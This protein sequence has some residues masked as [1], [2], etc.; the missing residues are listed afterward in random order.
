MRAMNVRYNG[1][2]RFLLDYDKLIYLPIVLFTLVTSFIS[3]WKHESFLTYAWD[4][5]AYEQSLWTTLKYGKLLWN[6]PNFGHLHIHL[7]LILFLIFPLYAIY[8][9]P[10]T[11]LVIQSFFVGMSALPVYLIAK[12]EFEDKKL[13]FLFASLYLLYTP[14]VSILNFDFHSDAFIP[15][16]LSFSIYYL[17]KEKW[18]KYLLFLF[19]TLMCKE[20]VPLVTVFLGIYIILTSEVK[21]NSLSNKCY[22]AGMLKKN[23]K[24]FFGFFTIIISLDWFLLAQIVMQY[25][26]SQTPQ[27]AYGVPYVHLLWWKRFGVSIPEI[28]ANI[29]LKPMLT[30]EALTYRLNEKIFYVI[31]LLAPFCFISFKKPW[32][33]LVPAPYLMSL[34]L[35]ENYWYWQLGLFY[36]SLIV[37]FVTVSSIYGIKSLATTHSGID[38]A[39]VKK[40]MSIVA[41]SILIFTL[42]G[43]S[44]SIPYIPANS[45]HNEALKRVIELIPQNASVITQNNI[46]PHLSHRLNVYPGYRH[47]LEADYILVDMT[48]PSFGEKLSTSF[49]EPPGKVLFDLVTK[50]NYTVVTAIDGII[51]LKRDYKGPF[52]IPFEQALLVKFFNNENFSGEPSFITLMLNVDWKHLQHWQD[53]SPFV[54]VKENNI[55]HFIH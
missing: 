27:V 30:L 19:L 3:I 50:Y 11:L 18:S 1:V 33:L 53:L 4:L 29:L 52:V 15:F 20:V 41:I 51:L 25:F 13:G 9:A 39:L 10:E 21:F 54:T 22:L 36:Q 6:T 2:S 24:L 7:D 45:L 49:Y 14:L 37:P 42:H 43:I 44:L 47:G 48:S 40:I 34:F 55:R 26:L 38:K 12:E 31:W 17:R 35:S 32:L 5:G 8:P 23:K 16:F 46:F 28:L